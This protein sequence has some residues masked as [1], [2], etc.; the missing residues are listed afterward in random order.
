MSIA[1]YGTATAFSNQAGLNSLTATSLVSIGVIDNTSE[2]ADDYF[3]EIAIANISETG[4]KQALVYV[5][6]SVDGTNYSDTTSGATNLKYVG[7]LDLNGLTAAGRSIALA[8][9]HLFGG[10]MPPKVEV[11]VKNDA[12]VTFAGSGNTAQYRSVKF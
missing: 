7:R 8:L 2:L 1:S 3:V 4:N 6:S 11:Y 12:G 10:I 9:A 5:S